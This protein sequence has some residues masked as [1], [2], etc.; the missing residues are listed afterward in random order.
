MAGFFSTRHMAVVLVVGV[1]AA[2][3]AG[4]GGEDAEDEAL[5]TGENAKDEVAE[6]MLALD[7]WEFDQSL[8]TGWRPY[9][10]REEYERAADLIAH[11][12]SHRTNLIEAH[13]GYLH[14][15]AGQLRAYHDDY[16]R[17]L[18]HLDQAY[19]TPDSMPD[20][21]PRSFN[22]LAAGERAF[23]RGDMTGVRAA[24]EKIRAMP[25]MSSR[26]SMFLE[27]LEFLAMQEGKTYKEAE[28][29]TPE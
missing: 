15:H 5:Q 3:G 28:L 29:S 8:E 11:Y 1:L 22:H 27:S 14:L 2:I 12:L 20:R 26:D 7:F 19:V 23:M 16:R 9:A 10:E 4:C 25:A 18:D 17:A 13:R 6:K 21:F 24:A